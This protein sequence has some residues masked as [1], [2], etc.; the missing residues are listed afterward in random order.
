MSQLPKEKIRV[1]IVKQYNLDDISFV[2]NLEKVWKMSEVVLKA[3][4]GIEEETIKVTDTSS[5]YES[6]SDD[7]FTV[8]IE[9]IVNNFTEVAGVRFNDISRYSN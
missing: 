3:E 2:E 1:L 4:Q 6:D 9:R 7:E 8:E 5:D